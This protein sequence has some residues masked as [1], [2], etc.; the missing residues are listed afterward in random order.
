LLYRTDRPH[1]HKAELVTQTLQAAR[2]GS[3]LTT[4][5]D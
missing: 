4:G 1:G 2:M 3:V 5:T